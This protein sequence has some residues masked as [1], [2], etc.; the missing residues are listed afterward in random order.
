MSSDNWTDPVDPSAG[1]IVRADHI[2]YALQNVQALKNGLVSDGSADSAIVHTHKTGTLRARP[3]PGNA[4]RLYI[5]TDLPI[6]LYDDGTEWVIPA[7]GGH[8]VM[9]HYE[10]F[11][12]SRPVS[13][14]ETTWSMTT[15]GQ[16][17][18]V[19]A[20]DGT[21]TDTVW[22]VT[23][24]TTDGSAVECRMVG[25]LEQ[26]IDPRRIHLLVLRIATASPT[27]TSQNMSFGLRSENLNAP[28]QFIG[29][30]KIDAA[31]WFGVLRHG[32]ADRSTAD[33]STTGASQFTAIFE[34]DGTEMKMYK[35]TFNAAGLITTFAT[36]AEFPDIM[37]YGCCRC[38]ND[39]AA[40]DS[41]AHIDTFLLHTARS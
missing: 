4:G 34:Y 25:N 1:T 8:S 11:A 26:N 21:L 28:E 10:E 40:A 23:T 15:N 13:T 29:L 41:R 2:T 37:L 22:R 18:N 16:G 38:Q 30:R 35:D 6:M 19:L 5:P 27:N 14:D 3:A 33:M 20:G 17:G 36:T 32:D 24:G 9:T 12:G 31:N 39:G 7:T